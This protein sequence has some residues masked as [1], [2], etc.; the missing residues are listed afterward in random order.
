MATKQ[1]RERFSLRGGHGAQ[2]RGNVSLS[3]RP[4]RG[5]VCE[6][7]PR[8]SLVGSYMLSFDLHGGQQGSESTAQLMCWPAGYREGCDAG[9]ML[10]FNLGKRSVLT[11]VGSSAA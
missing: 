2:P 7:E 10:E 4:L 3:P 9:K 11:R 1:L 8:G 5:C 6:R